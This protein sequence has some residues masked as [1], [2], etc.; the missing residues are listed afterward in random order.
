MR[1]AIRERAPARQSGGRGLRVAGGFI[2]QQIVGLEGLQLILDELAARGAIA[3]DGGLQL[4][5]LGLG[6]GGV[7]RGALGH[8]GGFRLRV[9]A[10][11]RCLVGGFLHHAVGLGLGCGGGLVGQ[12][13][14][15]DEGLAHGG[16]EVLE[17]AGLVV[18]GG[19]GLRLGQRA[20]L[21]LQRVAE[22]GQLAVQGNVL[23]NQR[24]ELFGDFVE[25]IVDLFNVVAAS[26]LSRENL[27]LNILYA[28][29][30]A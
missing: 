21:F 29:C 9:G 1:T 3:L 12:T 16:L 8:G 17:V 14:R 24:A 5:Q 30:H 4:V 7:G 25:E 2:E 18:V 10:E 28:D 11:L 22:L 15:A 23:A 13:L 26:G 20:L 6:R 27:L 19:L